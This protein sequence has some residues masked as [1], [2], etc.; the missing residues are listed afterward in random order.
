MNRWDGKRLGRGC[1]FVAVAGCLFGL[2]VNPAL[3]QVRAFDGSTDGDAGDGVTWNQALNWSGDDVPNSPSESASIDAGGAFD[4]DFTGLSATIDSL[5]IGADDKLTLGFAGFL[6]VNTSWVNEGEIVLE[7]F[8]Q[9]ATQRGLTNAATGTLRGAGLSTLS[10]VAN[11]GLTNFGTIA[12]GNTTSPGLPEAGFLN[13]AGDLLLGST[14]KIEIEIG[15]GTTNVDYD[16]I[17]VAGNVGLGGE[18]SVTLI[19]GF[20]PDASTTFSVLGGVFGAPG[21]GGAFTNIASGDRLFT[22][23]GAG[24][25]LVSYAATGAGQVELS[26]YQPIPEPS[27]LAVSAVASVFVLRRRRR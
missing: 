5:A 24:S 23:D 13:I 4:V 19:N 27:T 11:D 21:T 18:L 9:L 7:D 15:G 16:Q 22:E 26:D 20:T 10:Y 3:G 14:S 25:F 8:S 2:G 17:F 12:P 1:V 6:T